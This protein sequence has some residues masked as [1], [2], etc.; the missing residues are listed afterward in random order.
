MPGE[1]RLPE[2]PGD[3]P[4]AGFNRVEW[5][6]LRNRGARDAQD[7]ERL[8]HPTE[9]EIHDPLA[10]RDMAGAVQRI[11]QSIERGER[12]TVYGDY[13][14]DGLTAATLLTTTLEWIG[15]DVAAFIPSRFEEGYGLQEEALLKLAREGTRLVISVDCGVRAI[16]EVRAAQESGL[17]IIVTD[18]HDP[19]DELPPAVAVVNPK[20]VDDVYPFKDLSGVGLAFK[21]SQALV[22]GQV[23]GWMESGAMA[24]VAVGTIADIAP[25]RGENRT[26]AAR[27]LAQLRQAPPAGIAALIEVAGLKPQRL[28]GRDIGFSI[29]PR[30]NAVGRLGSATSAFRLLR[31]E[32]LT[33]A[34]PLATQLD[35]ANRERQDQTRA[36]LEQARSK[37]EGL[38]EVPPLIFDADPSYGEGLLGPAAAKLTEEWHRPAVLVSLR[39]EIGRGSARSVAGFHITDALEACAPLLERFGGHAAAAGFSVAADKVGELRSR[40][41]QLA[42]ERLEA[43]GAPPPLEIDALVAPFDINRQLIEFLDRLEPLGSGFPP[44]LLG[45][46]GMTVIDT[47]PVGRDKSHLKLVLRHR[48]RTVDAIAFRGGS[49]EVEPGTRID[50]A[51]FAERE[52]YMGLE[53]IR[54]NVQGIRP[55]VRAAGRAQG[56]G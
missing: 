10:L 22:G 54:W 52:V 48:D 55:S 1:W 16:A 21:L 5:A 12:I 27:G 28:T 38:S 20:R 23:T 50:L 31:A 15:A 53:G 35:Q 24:L 46:L 47:R 11:R 30:L 44:P 13:D 3:E 41:E 39:G 25:L 14:A 45:C 26:L 32:S 18:H 33:E 2:G 9:G 7:A 43:P 8:L 49:R 56:S 40:L 29:A 34:R 17:D 4:P 51:F 6:V 42:W 36:V 37:M 19:A